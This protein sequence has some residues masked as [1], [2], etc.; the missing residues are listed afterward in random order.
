MEAV[1]SSHCRDA[2]VALHSSL[3]SNS[4]LTRLYLG[5]LP[6][7]LQATSEGSLGADATELRS[8]H[9]YMVAVAELVSLPVEVADFE[10]HELRTPRREGGDKGGE[11]AGGVSFAALSRQQK[12]FERL[13]HQHKVRP[14][15]II[16]PLSPPVLSRPS[17]RGRGG[18]LVVG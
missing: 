11:N 5:H 1:H 3:T 13:R 15:H 16:A 9:Q 8:A 12:D 18:G 17:T 4:C 14:P 6:A 7:V 10:P 2:L